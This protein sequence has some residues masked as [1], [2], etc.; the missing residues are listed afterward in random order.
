MYGMG[1][2]GL[3]VGAQWV[4][5]SLSYPPEDRNRI[6][7]KPHLATPY[8]KQ[9]VASFPPWPRSGQ[10][11]F[12]VEKVALRQVS[13]ANLYSSKFSFLTI[14]WGRYNRPISGQRFE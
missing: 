3:Y 10:L 7:P 8:L 14:T 9:L 4:R 2:A 1:K 11:G 13:P 12:V 5:I 6:H